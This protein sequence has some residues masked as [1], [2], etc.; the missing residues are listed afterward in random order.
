LID[1]RAGE[2]KELTT[3]A[4]SYALFV[5]TDISTVVT[6]PDSTTRLFQI[7]ASFD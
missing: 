4:S 6:L 2:F 1:L 3:P 7:G 5:T